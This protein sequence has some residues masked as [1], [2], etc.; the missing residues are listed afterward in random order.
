[1]PIRVARRVTV[2]R[3][4]R[5]RTHIP[6]VGE[7]LGGTVLAGNFLRE[8]VEGL[9][10]VVAPRLVGGFVLYVRDA[11][12]IEGGPEGSACRR[13]SLLIADVH[14]PTYPVGMVRAG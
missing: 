11:A 2:G 7:W 1:M 13:T 12:G 8:G 3:W 14:A 9:D 6:E 4:L 10:P 5:G